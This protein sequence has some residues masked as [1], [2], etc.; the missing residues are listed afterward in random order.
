MLK[1]LSN[2]NRLKIFLRL[3]SCCPDGTVCDISSLQGECVGEL[4]KDLGISLSTVS[5][6]IKE[7]S[8]AGLILMNRKG[9]FITCR[10]NAEALARLSVLF[11]RYNI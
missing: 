10:A 1:A 2:P 4:G 6:H 8:Q 9:K 7:L 5:H 11:E 3:L